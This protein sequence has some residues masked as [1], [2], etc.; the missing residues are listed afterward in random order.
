MKLGCMQTFPWSAWKKIE[1]SDD[2][3]HIDNIFTVNSSIRM[4]LAPKERTCSQLHTHAKKRR[5]YFHSLL[6]QVKNKGVM[7]F[8]TNPVFFIIIISNDKGN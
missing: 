5:S 6:L 7:E 4:F 1:N 2:L 3:L 8:R